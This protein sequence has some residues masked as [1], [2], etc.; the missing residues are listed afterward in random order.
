MRSSG[1]SSSALVGDGYL[2]QDAVGPSADQ[3]KREVSL[4]EV[5]EDI[6]N[7]SGDGP[8]SGRCPFHDDQHASLSVYPTS[9]GI[10]RWKCH[11]LSCGRGGSVIDW[12][13]EY[14]GLSFCEAIDCLARTAML[15]PTRHRGTRR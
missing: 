3:I 4:R 14:D 15:G 8:F 1:R 11:A 6:V 2:R 9:S 12:V 5:V 10:W 7:L 13:M